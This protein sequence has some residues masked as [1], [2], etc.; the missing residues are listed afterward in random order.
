MLDEAEVWKI[1]MAGRGAVW[2]S[3]VPIVR[4]PSEN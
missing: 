2:K 1:Y 4:P 3:G